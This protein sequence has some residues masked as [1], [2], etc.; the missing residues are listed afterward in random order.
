MLEIKM[1]AVSKSE[2]LLGIMFDQGEHEIKK[3]V[4]VPFTRIRIGI[5]FLT[6][7]LIWYTKI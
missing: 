4:W 5:I 7:D 6:L 3:E 1:T 2:S